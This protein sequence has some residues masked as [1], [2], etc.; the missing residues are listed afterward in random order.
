SSH[1]N[2]S[3]QPHFKG[4][5][6]HFMRQDGPG[7]RGRFFSCVVLGECCVKIAILEAC[8]IP[9]VENRKTYQLTWRYCL[10]R[11]PVQKKQILR[12]LSGSSVRPMTLTAM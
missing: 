9:L 1:E 8:W 11:L 5:P 3:E 10:H 7:R 4:I 2:D 12:R 6:S